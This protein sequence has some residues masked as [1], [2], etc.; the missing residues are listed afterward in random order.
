MRTMKRTR[1]KRRK[2]RKWIRRETRK[3]GKR[4]RTVTMKFACRYDFSW[5]ASKPNSHAPSNPVG[6]SSH[7]N[8]S[9]ME[10][11][12]KPTG[13][14]EMEKNERDDEKAEEKLDDINV[15]SEIDQWDQLL[16]FL[17]KVVVLVLV[18]ILMIMMNHSR[19]HMFKMTIKIRHDMFANMTCLQ[20][21]QVGAHCAEAED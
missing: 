10:K 6:S 14:E 1:R 2:G 5:N 11:P 20:T 7:Q 17:K 3:G 12:G 8:R 13:G 21:G 15:E 4:R 16:A 9:S 18:L 19:W